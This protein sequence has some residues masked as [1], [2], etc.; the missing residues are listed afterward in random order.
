MLR[1]TDCTKDPIETVCIII[2]LHKSK[3]LFFRA[4]TYTKII[5]VSPSPRGAQ[6]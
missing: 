1:L 6:I 5:M 3:L 2:I 4:L